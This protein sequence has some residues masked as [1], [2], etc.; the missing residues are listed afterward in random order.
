[1]VTDKAFMP[2]GSVTVS[3]N[4][5]VSA[6]NFL[7]RSFIQDGKAI[8]SAGEVIDTAQNHTIVGHPVGVLA[9]KTQI[10]LRSLL[11]E[12]RQVTY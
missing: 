2:V 5:F 3:I 9:G 10:I 8:N 12:M 11:S 4:E 1:M 7:D 6:T